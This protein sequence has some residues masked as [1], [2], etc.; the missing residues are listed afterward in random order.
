MTTNKI[1]TFKDFYKQKHSNYLY[2]RFACVTMDVDEIIEMLSNFSNL[3]E[4][5]LY[6]EIS[7]CI[8]KIGK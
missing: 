5:E 3:E 7:T 8:E 2:I 1:T 4:D 6:E